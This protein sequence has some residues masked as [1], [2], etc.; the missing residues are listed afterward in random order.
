MTHTHLFS[1]F[2]LVLVLFN[3]LFFFYFC[4]CCM[5]LHFMFIAESNH[6]EICQIF[7]H[8]RFMY[9][10]WGF[11]NNL[12]DLLSWS[13]ADPAEF[14]AQH[15]F[16]TQR[17]KRG[18]FVCWAKIDFCILPYL[19]PIQQSSYQ[20]ESTIIKPEAKIK[21]TVYATRHFMFARDWGQMKF[22]ERWKL[23]SEGQN[24]WQ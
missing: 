9:P 3:D 24:S 21:S 2:P 17:E 6:C 1:V 13:R 8:W 14:T 4:F 23:I 19:M 10:H 22:N 12:L 15:R 20:S 16:T 7:F 11:W 5:H 18:W